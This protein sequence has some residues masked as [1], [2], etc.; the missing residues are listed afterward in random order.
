MSLLLLFNQPVA[1]GGDFPVDLTLGRICTLTQSGLV[2][3]YSPLSLDKIDALS[4]IGLGVGY[5]PL[6]LSLSRTISGSA[7]QP[8]AFTQL[9]M[10]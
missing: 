6:G 10:E 7:A 2:D 5:S 1:G 8:F 4:N 9:W 3:A